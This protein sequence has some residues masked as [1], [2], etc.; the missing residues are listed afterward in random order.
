MPVLQGFRG[1]N[2]YGYAGNILYA[3]LSKGTVTPKPYPDNLKRSVFG[4]LGQGVEARTAARPVLC[5]PRLGR[6]GQANTA[7]IE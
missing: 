2:H 1:G 4:G 3:D 5:C 7:E 6:R